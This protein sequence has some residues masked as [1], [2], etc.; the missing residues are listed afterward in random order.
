MTYISQ[1]MAEIDERI[2]IAR[3]NLRDLIEQATA[4]SAS[5]DEERISQRI[6]E[7]E[8]QIEHLL[9]RRRELGGDA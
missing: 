5:G 7:Q 2:A 8:A 1:N 9:I 6:S 4:D 3:E